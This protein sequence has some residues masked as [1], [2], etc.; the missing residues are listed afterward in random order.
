MTSARDPAAKRRAGTR[1]RRKRPTDDHAPPPATLD[2]VA[3]VW[4]VDQ[5]G[6]ARFLSGPETF[7]FIAPFLGR[8]RSAAEAASEIGVSAPRVRYWATRALEAG[9]V[10]AA[11]DAASG[12]MRYRMRADALF[13]P[14]ALTESGT[15]DALARAW[16]DPWQA[17]FV[18]SV[19]RLIEDDG[20]VGLRIAREPDGAINAVLARTA[21]HDVDYARLPPLSGGWITDMWLDEPEARELQCELQAVIDRYAQRRGGAVPY[22]MRLAL[23][24]MGMPDF[25]PSAVKP[26]QPLLRAKLRPRSR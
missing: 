24:P 10:V 2:T 9:L 21:L 11:R 6:I 19:T 20:P 13:L 7:R 23:A 17:V 5:P 8:A 12:V 3:P 26:P 14:A 22:I 1:T 18:R 4:T 15:I 25:L 16:S